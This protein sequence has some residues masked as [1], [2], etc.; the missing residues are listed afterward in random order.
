MSSPSGALLSS[1]RSRHLLED[2]ALGNGAAD[3]VADDDQHDGEQER[4]TP[5]PGREVFLGHG[6][7][8]EVQQAG[9][10]DHADR[11]TD[12]RVRAEQAALALGSVL[13]CHQGG[14]APFT[15]GGEALDDAEQDQQDR[16]PDADLGVG[17]QHAD[18]RRGGTHHDEGEDQHGL[19]AEAVTQVAGDDGAERAEQEADADEGKGQD[20]RQA[21]IGGVQRCEEQR[22]QQRCRQLGEDEEVVPLDGGPDQGAR[23]DLAFL[24]LAAGARLRI[25]T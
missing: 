7:V 2:G 1:L 10:E 20:L 15:A 16:S 12:L 13:D 17:R 22:R 5:A 21:R 25:D 6:R 23:E 18:Q 9:G 19:A 14:A 11:N 3:Q 4:H 8:E 24:M